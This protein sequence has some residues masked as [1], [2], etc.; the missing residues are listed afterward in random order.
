MCFT[1]ITPPCSSPYT[2]SFFSCSSTWCSSFTPWC[3]PSHLHTF[4][5]P[6]AALREGRK[7]DVLDDGA[8]R[9]TLV[10]SMISPTLLHPH[11]THHTVVMDV[12]I[13]HTTCALRTR[14]EGRQKKD[15]KNKNKFFF[16]FIEPVVHL[17]V[18]HTHYVRSPSLV[19]VWFCSFTPYP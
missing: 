14:Q 10:G 5:F 1:T 9:Y 3:P 19:P 17:C 16:A 12:G 13:H 15:F 6:T 2:W 4:V 7:M 18:P 11:H 8:F